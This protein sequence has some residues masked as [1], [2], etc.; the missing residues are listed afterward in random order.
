MPIPEE[1]QT[2]VNKLIQKTK[3]GNVNWREAAD[4]GQF[5]VP[6]GDVTIS[7]DRSSRKTRS[8]QRLVT[9]KTVI[10]R[11]LNSEASLVDSFTVSSVSDE[12]DFDRMNLLYEGAKRRARRVDEVIESIDNELDSE[13]EIG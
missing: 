3:S 12:E 10:F 4:A 6:I 2:I 8:A 13:G 9:A 5:F 7:L 1:F 11:V